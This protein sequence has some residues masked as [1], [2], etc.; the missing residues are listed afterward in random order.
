MIIKL[1]IFIF[2]VSWGR[3]ELF[4]TTPKTVDLSNLGMLKEDFF[5][6]T[7][8]VA[9][10]YNAKHLILRGNKF[11]RF[12]D[13][14]TTLSSLL[15]LDLSY[16]NLEKFFFLC[17]KEYNLESLNVSH[18]QIE[19]IND[20]ALSDKII[21][22]KILDVSYNN[23]Y[24]VNDTMLQHMINLDFLSLASNPI[25]ENIDEFV[26]R[27]LTNLKHLNL[28]NIS[29]PY[30]SPLLF[31]PLLKLEFLDLS[32]NPIE[33]V[34]PLPLGLKVLYID[35]TNIM[36]LGAFIMPELHFL[37]IERSANLTSVLLNNFENLTKL[38]ILSLSNSKNLAE[39]R[40]K[41]QMNSNLLPSL[42]RCY[43]VNCSMETISADLKRIVEKTE[44]LDFQNNPWICD[45]R[46]TWLAA[47]NLTTDLKNNFRCQA[48]LKHRGKLL[49]D[50]PIDELECDVPLLSNPTVRFTLYILLW[51]CLVVLLLSLVAALFAYYW[52]RGHIRRWMMK[53]RHHD[54]DT[55]SYTNVVESN[56]DLVRILPENPEQ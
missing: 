24:V 4:S 20:Q 32:D 17:Q 43:L 3:C 22:L 7:Q 55:V 39:M 23:L 34:P 12:V 26:F 54:N 36:H 14:S 21:K 1:L 46:L 45:C 11:D 52:K 38:E 41:P 53:I 42:K 51:F 33:D 56:H 15:T 27:N 16:N 18:N 28:R 47:M 44:V 19:Y 30:F 9:E 25:G 50:V 13:C 5:M 35:G 8:H 31:E 37:S 10:I 6:K 29:S 40:L 49:H 48:P 2:I